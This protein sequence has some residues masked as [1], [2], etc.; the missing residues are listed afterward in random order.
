MNPYADP[1]L[2]A[3]AQCDEPGFL[4]VMAQSAAWSALVFVLLALGLGFGGHAALADHGW[5]AWL[6]PVLGLVIAGLAAL[7][8]F[9][10]LATAIASLFAERIAAAVETRFYPGLPA[11]TPA[12]LLHQLWEG[13]AF[14]ARLLGLQLI[15]LAL[16]I[17][18]PGIGLLLGWAI[19][20]IAVGR[21]LFLTV[22]MQR[23]N[24]PAALAAYR[25]RRGPVLAMGALI[26]AAGLVPLLNL[27]AAVLGIAAMVHVLHLPVA[28]RRLAG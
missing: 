14:G 5:L 4:V 11:A 1:A 12:P 15:A 17:F 3:L 22:A 6:G 9:I 25:A 16:G 13:L 7:F 8:L 2:R 20:A 24:R 10:P 23:M 28:T 19:A 18:L 27:V 26:T 21:G